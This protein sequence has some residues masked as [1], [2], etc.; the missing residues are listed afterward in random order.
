[1]RAITN[2][3]RLTQGMWDDALRV[4][5]AQ[6][7]AN[8]SKQVAYA[9][10]VSLGGDAGAA[11]LQ[12]FGLLEA[13]IDFAMESGAFAHAFELTRAGQLKAKLPEVHLKYAM[14]LEDEGRFKEAEAEFLKADKPKEAVD[15]YVHQQDWAAALRIAEG[16]D[17]AS[18]GDITLAQAAVCVE[19]QDYAGAQAM[20]LKAKRPEAAIQMYKQARKWEEAIRVAEDYLPSA[21]HALHQ[22]LAASM[23]GGSLSG[24]GG[25]SGMGGMG[26]GGTFDSVKQQYKALERGGD[27]SGAIDVILR[28]MTKELTADMD[29]LEKAWEDAVDMAM[30]GVQSRCRE[31]VFTVAA[32]LVDIG[33]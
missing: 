10:A 20:F 14:W 31:V 23:G 30:A 22:E 33:R 21:V 29:A 1:M 13:A 19:R 2:L 15:M 17:P 6:G 25:G 5:R 11:L 27:A 8:A 16:F 9:W 3:V 18:L 26:M 12:K 4:A 32:R 24:G 28:D 7:G